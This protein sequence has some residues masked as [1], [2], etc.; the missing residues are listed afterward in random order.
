MTFS[1]ALD[2]IA[3]SLRIIR[4]ITANAQIRCV[5]HAEQLELDYEQEHIRIDTA[6]ETTIH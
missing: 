5:S 3:I 2:E 4:H 1:E 6:P